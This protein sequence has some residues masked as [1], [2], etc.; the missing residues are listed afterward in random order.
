MKAIVY[1]PYR[2]AVSA[3]GKSTTLERK[4]ITLFSS[5]NDTV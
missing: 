4:L 5:Q 1:C 3:F 2:V